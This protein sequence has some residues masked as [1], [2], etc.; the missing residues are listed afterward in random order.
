MSIRRNLNVFAWF[1]ALEGFSLYLPIAVLYFAELTGSYA[2]G[3]SIFSI[4]LISS[5]FFEVPTGI[6]SD[7]VGRSRTLLLGS[8][9]E[10]L[11]VLSY[12]LAAILPRP[13]VGLVVGAL[14]QGASAAF[15]SG[16]E[17]ALMHETLTN[18]RKTDKF[19]DVYGRS[20]AFSQAAMATSAAL[21]T[22]IAYYSSF[23][24]VVW[25]SLIPAVGAMLLSLLFRDPVVHG[26]GFPMKQSIQ[27]FHQ[28][29]Q[30]LYTNKKLRSFSLLCMVGNG[31]GLASHRFESA[32]YAPLIPIWAIGY[33]R[34]LKQICG[35]MSYWYSGRVVKY[36]S[37]L[38]ALLAGH[39]FTLIVKGVAVVLNTC[40][41]PFIMGLV[42]LA[43]GTGSSAQQ[44][45]LQKEFT[46]T[47]RATLASIVSLGSNL[48]FG[49][50]AILMGF[51]A[52]VTSSRVAML[53]PLSVTALV[54]SCY[55]VLY[56]KEKG[57]AA[58]KKQER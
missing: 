29:W 2:V 24:V 15:F 56:Q 39:V 57:G 54:S 14:C 11:G 17:E 6:F 44:T 5:S 40:A 42:N 49:I 30:V 18:L 37:C 4:S 45:L 32:F 23:A 13:L 53:V 33:A 20:K 43:Y 36:L 34:L 46:N 3:M 47:Q 50:A 48:I 19:A 10:A 22:T 12:A 28:C 8:L 35:T 41:S 51:V 58:Y 16:T 21:G 27:H 25:L 26:G 31:F 52:D 38:G 55:Y 9:F 7:R 1:F